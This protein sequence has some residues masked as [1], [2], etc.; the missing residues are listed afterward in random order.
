VFSGNYE[1]PG[2]GA[3][4]GGWRTDWVLS[5]YS[6]QPQS[7]HCPVSTGSGT[8]CYALVVGDP[9]EGRHDVDQFYNPAAFVTPPNVTSIG[10]TD[11][12]PL[13]G[14][15]TPVTGPPLRQLDMGLS[16]QFGIGGGR[17]FEVRAEAFNVTNTPAFNLPGSLDYRTPQTFASI[18]QMRNTPRQFQIGAKVYW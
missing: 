15:R 17:R 10:Q 4:L 1:L 18:T 2:S 16:K 3:I 6:G 12:S 14:D 7:I 13:G 11:F 5:L 8:D 9:Y